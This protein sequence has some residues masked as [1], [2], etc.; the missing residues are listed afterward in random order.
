MIV[1][2]DINCKNTLYPFTATRSVADIRIG[3]LTIREKW[4]RL[5]NQKVSTTSERNTSDAEAINEQQISA[6]IIPSKQWLDHFINK[7]NTSDTILKYPWQI[8]QLNDQALRD[9]FQLI[10]RDRVSQQL[11]STNK[12]ICCMLYPS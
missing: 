6:N 1:L 11:S 7:Q 2:E 9:D 3:I 4:E 10:T 12:V 8:F 5:L